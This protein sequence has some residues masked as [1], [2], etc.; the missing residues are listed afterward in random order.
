MSKPIVLGVVTARAGSK[1]IPEKNTKLLAGKPLIAYTID[2]AR[3]SGVFDRLVITTDDD[4]LP[5]RM[6]DTPLELGS[7][8]TA[9]L[10]EERLRSMVEGYYT[11]RGLDVDGR[12]DPADLADLRL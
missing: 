12:P 7:G 3:A 11:G 1:G 5:R 6:L 10:T 4:T 2:A 9:T 8:R